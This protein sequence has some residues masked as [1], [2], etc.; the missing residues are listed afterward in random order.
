MNELK[1]LLIKAFNLELDDSQDA[2][3][4]TYLYNWEYDVTNALD[5]AVKLIE[6]YT[7]KKCEKQLDTIV[8][9]LRKEIA[10]GESYERGEVYLRIGIADTENG[11]GGSVDY[12]DDFWVN[13]YNQ[14]SSQL[15][16]NKEEV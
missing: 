3:P 11:C 12:D 7:A 6:T 15:T 5:D 16:N 2:K 10:I 14:L 1:E 13:V 9:Y 4:N 8:R